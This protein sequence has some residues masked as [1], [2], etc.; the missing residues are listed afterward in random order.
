MTEDRQSV[1]QAIW[2][3][4]PPALI[5]AAR[6]AV[7]AWLGVPGTEVMLIDYHQSHLVPFGDGSGGPPVPVNNHPAGQAYA[8]VRVVRDDDH[9]YL[10]LAVYGER[11][12]VLAVRLPA[13]ADGDAG[14]ALAEDLGLVADTLGRALRLA[15]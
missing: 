14:E 3:A 5:E 15:D 9:L 6:D 2:S 1:E 12:G 11:T 7:D 4:R 13:S 8:T 10:P